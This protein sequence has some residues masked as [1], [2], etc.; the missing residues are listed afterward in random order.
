VGLCD[1]RSKLPDSVEYVLVSGG[2]HQGF[3]LCSH[4]FFDDAATVGW[5]EQADFAHARTAAFFAAHP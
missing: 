2:N 3:A 4:Q 5:A 1:A